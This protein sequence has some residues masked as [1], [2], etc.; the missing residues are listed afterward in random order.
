M[1]IGCDVAA[2]AEKII[3]LSGQHIY[4]VKVTR[5]GTFSCKLLMENL[6]PSIEQSHAPSGNRLSV[7]RIKHKVMRG[8]LS[9]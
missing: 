8:R 2:D 7:K 3:I 6:F 5:T 4:G 1:I 9:P